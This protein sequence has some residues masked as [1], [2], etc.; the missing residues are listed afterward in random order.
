MS[1]AT[2]A[3]TMKRSN[4]LFEIIQILRATPRPVTAAALAEQLEVSERTVYRDIVALQAM[5]TPIEGEAGV[6]YIM[7]R[8]YDLPPLNFDAEEVEALQV[9]LSMLA[10]TGDSALQQA[11]ARISAKIE[12]LHN[13][14]DW[15]QVAPWG[16]PLDDPALGCVSKAL[17]RD[18]VK[19]ERKLRITY[20]DASGIETQRVV[21]PIGIVYHVEC[22]MLATWCELRN[23]FRHFRTDRI[24]ACEELDDHFTGQGDTLRLLWLEQQAFTAPEPVA[25]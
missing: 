18:A 8:G 25:G 13:R 1:A 24:W 19:A 22:A 23:T 9:G 5:R 16:A 10:R 6:G 4:R 11:A 15:L 17:L 7:R 2:G 12:A 14:A 3:N 20:R 21:R